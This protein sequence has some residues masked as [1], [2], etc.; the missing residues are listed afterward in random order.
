MSKLKYNVDVLNNEQEERIQVLISELQAK[1]SD[2]PTLVSNSV[3]GIK[4]QVP[5]VETMNS[6]R[7][8]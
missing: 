6:F 8:C 3:T 7:N 2:V 5:L 4:L 1:I